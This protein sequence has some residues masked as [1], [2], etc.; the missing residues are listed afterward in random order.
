M[1][2]L[3]KLFNRHHTTVIACLKTHK[4]HIDVFSNGRR[5][6]ELYT[7]KFLEGA[8]ILDQVMVKKK[9]SAR[10]LKYRVVLY[11]DN[12]ETLDNYEI[13]TVKNLM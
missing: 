6:N 12:P 10:H 13:M 4:K 3:G 9:T 1:H 5:V 2:N 7:N 8:E 11:T